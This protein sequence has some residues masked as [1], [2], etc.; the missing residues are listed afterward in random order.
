MGSPPRVRSAKSQIR[1]A[2]TLAISKLSA[3]PSPSIL[4]T[5]T[6]SASR[7]SLIGRLSASTYGVTTPTRR[8]PWPT[9]AC[10]TAAITLTVGI[11]DSSLMR[12]HSSA[13]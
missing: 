5:S 6:P 1:A 8:A 3:I 10:L 12:A 9:I 7:L 11:P 13:S 4:S 2:G